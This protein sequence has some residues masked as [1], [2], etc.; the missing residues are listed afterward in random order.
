MLLRRY[1]DFERAP[2]VLAEVAIGPDAVEDAAIGLVRARFTGQ[3][4]RELRVPAVERR[5]LSLSLAIDVRPLIFALPRQRVP[6]QANSAPPSVYCATSTSSPVSTKR[7]ASTFDSGLLR[8]RTVSNFG[9][10]D[11]RSCCP[12][13]VRDRRSRDRNARRGCRWRKRRKRDA[14]DRAV[15]FVSGRR[16][17][18]VADR[19][20]EDAGRGGPVRCRTNSPSIPARAS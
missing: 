2:A 19:L 14:S 6:L 12:G 18:R 13:S 8:K 17:V 7:C 3:R 5:G 20:A 10:V 4:I 1:G 9:P 16:G 11:V 15:T